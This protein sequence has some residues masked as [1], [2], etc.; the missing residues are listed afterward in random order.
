MMRRYPPSTIY[1]YLDLPST[2]IIQTHNTHKHNTTP[3]SQTLAQA[4]HTLSPNTTHTTA[5][6]QR[7][8]SHFPHVPP[9]LIKPKPNPVTHSPPTPLTPPQAKHIYMSHTLHLHLSPHSSLARRLHQTKHLNHVYPHIHTH[10]NLP[11]PH[12]SIAVTLA[13]LHFRKWSRYTLTTLNISQQQT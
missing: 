1:R 12:T 8:I 4:A 7:H 3:P 9:E 11:G 13:P 6:K 2:Q 10:C 5:T